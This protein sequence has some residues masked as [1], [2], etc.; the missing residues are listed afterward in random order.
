M[1]I[2]DFNANVGKENMY[3]PIIGPD[4]LRETRN[5]N[6]M[7]L[8]HFATSQELKISSTYLTRKYIHKYMWISSN[9]RVHNQID[10][11]LI[12]KRRRLYQKGENVQRSGF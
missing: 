10:H 2:C 11:T 3:R 9:R 4:S 6:S 5:D 1:K 12:N 8:I 7:R